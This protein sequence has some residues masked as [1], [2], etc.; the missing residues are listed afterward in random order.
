MGKSHEQIM[1]SISKFVCALKKIEQNPNYGMH[2]CGKTYYINLYIP[3]GT[4]GHSYGHY[5]DHETARKAV[6]MIA[7]EYMKSLELVREGKVKHP[8]TVRELQLK[9]DAMFGEIQ[10]ENDLEIVN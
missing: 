8:A 6:L 9:H 1:T 10:K 3:R 7:H 5:H 2:L 4:G